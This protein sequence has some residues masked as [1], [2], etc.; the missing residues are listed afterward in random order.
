MHVRCPLEQLLVGT[1]SIG[2]ERQESL[3]AFA[4]ALGRFTL[5]LPRSKLCG[6][7][8]YFA[9]AADGSTPPTTFVFIVYTKS[10]KADILVVI[11]RAQSRLWVAR[12]IG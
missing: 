2:S 5:E 1:V 3:S 8:T 12:G 7:V 6:G 10:L 11:R 9:N 4:H